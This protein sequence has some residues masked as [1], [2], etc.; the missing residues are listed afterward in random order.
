MPQR[1]RALP[2]P[3]QRGPAA[4][5]LLGYVCE[6][7]ALSKTRGLRLPSGPVLTFISANLF[8]FKNQLSQKEIIDYE[9]IRTANAVLCH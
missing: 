6:N 9:N 5:L 3:E 7:G 2:V 4:R 8:H 1:G